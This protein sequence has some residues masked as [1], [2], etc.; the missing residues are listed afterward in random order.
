M[1][2]DFL[3]PTRTV[4]LSL[5]HNILTGSEA[6]AY[7]HAVGTKCCF[8]EEKAVETLVEYLIPPNAKTKNT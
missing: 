8:Y 3:F 4:H 2:L 5:L 7:S 6:H 1:H